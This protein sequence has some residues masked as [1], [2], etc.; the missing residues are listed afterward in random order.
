MYLA[1][2]Y[3]TAHNGVH[4][5][6]YRQ[7]FQGLDVYNASWVVNLAPDGTVLSTGGTL[8]S[9]PMAVD[10][11]SIQSPGAAVRAAVAT[12]NPAL[13]ANYAPFPSEKAPRAAGGLA[14]RYSAG[15]LSADVEGKLVW[16]GSRGAL[17]LA[18]MFTVADGD[19]IQA[20]AVEASTGAVLDQQPMSFF[21]SPL[22]GLVFDKESPEPT[23]YGVRASGAPAYV[24]RVLVP[25]TGNA[26]ASP[27]GWV[28]GNE[29]AGN[30][31]IAGTNPLGQLLLPPATA[32]AV[33]GS[34]SFPLTLGP[35][36]PA[37]T[38]YSE[39]ATTNLFYWINRA[40]DLHYQYGFDEAAGN[41]QGNN[42]G[43]GG[44]GSDAV[45]AYAQYG[46]AY[47]GGAQL[48]NA[49][50]TAVDSIDGA[51]SMIAMF[52]GYSSP[53]GFFTDGSYDAEVIV[54]EYTHGVSTRLVADGYSTFQGRSMGEAW[55]D[56]YA[57]EYLA[58]SGT[59]PDGIY[60]PAQYL[61][62]SWGYGIRSH[63]YSTDLTVNPLTYSQLG[64]VTGLGPEVHADG[65]IWM[66]AMWEA[67]ASLIQQ[68]GETEGRRRIR[69]LVMDG[70]KL[71]VPAPS[72]VDMR[73]AILL[74]DRVDFNGESQNQLWAAFAKRG[75]GALA[76]SDGAH[77]VH[78]LASAALPSATGQLAFYDDSFVAGEPV[79]VVLSDS[80]YSQPTVRI[81]VTSS[82]GDVEDLAL[83]RQGS[84]Y[85]GGISSSTA[86]VTEGNGV[87][88]VATG[89]AISIHYFDA[90][91]AD[92]SPRLI[93]KTVSV[94]QPYAVYYDTPTFS[95][96]NEVRA[97]TSRTPVRVSLP[98]DFLYFGKKY[99]S[100]VVYPTG[101]IAFENSISTN[102]LTGG[103][104]D[105]AELRHIN[106]IAPLFTNLTFGASQAAEGIYVGFPSPKAVTVRW[107]A[108][109]LTGLSPNAGDPVN[110]AV[111][112]NDDGSVLAQ[113]GSG[114]TNLQTAQVSSTCGAPNVVGLSNGHDVYARNYV[115]RT[116]TNVTVRMDPPYN[117]SSIPVSTIET[118]APNETADNVV[119]VSGLAY[120][121]NDYITRVEVYI[122]DVLRGVTSNGI[123]R[124]SA[125][126]GKDSPDCPYIGYELAINLAPLKLAAGP[127]RLWVRATNT[128]GAFSIGHDQQVTFNVGAAPVRPAKG[129]IEF[130]QP[131]AELSG[132]VTLRGYA[133]FD[134]LYVS[135]V[136]ML[137]DGLVYPGAQYGVSRPD[138]CGTLTPA[139]LDC[140]AIGWI[141]SLNTRSGSPPLPDG[142]HTMQLR[143]RDE[144]GRYSLVPEQ[145]VPF[146][147]KNGA[148]VPPTGALTSITPNQMLSGTVTISGYAYSPNST[149]LGV[150]LYVDD[151]NFGTARYGLA[152]PE[153]CQQ[154]PTVTACPNIGF[155]ISLD[156]RRLSNGPHV[157]GV[158]IVD[159]AGLTITIPNLNAGGMNITVNNP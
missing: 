25:L 108:E 8:Y 3:T 64:R 11:G 158:D 77:T 127:H 133:Y 50:F 6:V 48:R 140:P 117:F 59:P 145:P 23:A 32:K 17:V 147:V 28:T 55:S 98:F 144:S 103:C 128:R 37:P 29:T 24:E 7:R 70:M 132:A 51:A 66:E 44:V 96:S 5:L 2:D 14:V 13:G 43:R 60:A 106:G 138:V 114:N 151:L 49:F 148:Q 142:P 19:N 72:M 95:F 16:Y 94:R 121:A 123:P 42:F 120:D 159:A 109:T 90:D 1:K 26:T 36:A 97:T 10:L 27:Q 67:R 80:N 156:T 92:G 149:V 130:P 112:L 107:A 131:N 45:M 53:G 21:E 154:L 115:M 141:M 135:R 113:Y 71:S 116:L 15:D 118:P 119:F 41:F 52:A 155:S 85:V 100:M 110:F 136:D 34:F 75:L 83:D 81:R 22:T 12:V 87:L 105:V 122:D 152:E 54:H 102:L 104:T 76:Y 129:A 126:V 82:S 69:L 4:H 63:P 40:H 61:F 33:N 91:P 84:V 139:P 99:R 57:I 146:T 73:D 39:A 18:W 47:P 125:C 20:V 137:I 65:E 62:Q 30:N 58:P 79:R 134:D 143:V 56:F 101:V 89:D 88:N 9:A 46:S 153:V 68:F 35:D 111:T 74:A 150:V 38:L 124:A 78:I 157:L 31:V 86:A 93:Q